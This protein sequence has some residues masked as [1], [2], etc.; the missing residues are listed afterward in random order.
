MT[1]VQ[2]R[3]EYKVYNNTCH[4]FTEYNGTI[5]SGTN[6][7]KGKQKGVFSKKQILIL[8][9]L[10]NNT[11]GIERI[12]YTNPNKFE[13]VAEMLQALNG[14]SIATWVEELNN[15]KIKGL[16]YYSNEGEFKELIR[17]LTNLSEKLRK[18]GFRVLANEADKKIKELENTRKQ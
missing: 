7:M 9:D 12:D 6:E 13:S 17:I 3:L 10:L 18:S 16:Y 8:F 5:L 2:N 14:K 1:F 15:Y 11:G 4:Y